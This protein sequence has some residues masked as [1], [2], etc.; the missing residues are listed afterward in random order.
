MDDSKL[1]K[2]LE[3][4]CK[5]HA[6]KAGYIKK[7]KRLL[8]SKYPEYRL[9][10]N[11]IIMRMHNWYEDVFDR[12]L[13][14]YIRPRQKDEWIYDDDIIKMLKARLTP[15]ETRHIIIFN[16]GFID[17]KNVI[18]KLFG[19]SKKAR[20][21]IEKLNRLRNAIAHRYSK[22]SRH[23]FYN[24]QNILDNPKV[25]D[26]FAYDYFKILEEILKIETALLDALDKEEKK[27]G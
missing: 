13:R 17:K 7:F 3:K 4:I 2:E 8:L 27:Y 23:F 1:F 19:L 22:E 5:E 25:L 21:L 20:D 24:G 15:E 26:L 11:L 6:I 16:L 14:S 12:I 18:H 10:F 9:E